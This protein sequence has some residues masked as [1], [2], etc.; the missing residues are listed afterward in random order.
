M[1]FDGLGEEKDIFTPYLTL[2]FPEQSVLPGV[3]F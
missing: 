3:A 2:G 1:S